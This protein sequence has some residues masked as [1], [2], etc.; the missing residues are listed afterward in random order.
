VPRVFVSRRVPGR[1]RDELERLFELDVHD[2]EF[3]PAR[4][5]LLRRVAGVDGLV[6]VPADRVD[7]E[8]FEA[9]GRALR[10]V[11]NYGVGIDNVDLGA[12]KRRDVVVTNTPDVL[13]RPTAELAIALVLALLRRVAEGD[14]LLRSRRPWPWAPTFMLGEGLEGKTLGIVGY[15]RIGREVARLAEAVGMEVISTA[16]L[17]LEDLLGRADVVTLHVPLTGDTRHLIDDDALARMRPAAYVVNTARG[18]VVDERALIR[19]LREGRIAGAALDVFER[20]PDVEAGLLDL[21]NV[22]LTPHLGSAT[23]AARDAMGMLC[24]E[25]LRDVLVDGQRPRYTV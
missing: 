3:P 10:V 8:L 7:E 11:A 9:A 21:D 18:A 23:R 22:V 19:A 24:V 12:A 15:G 4:E 14:R 6:M 5:E 1:V 20:E 13:T 17:P 2:S 16:P 25:A